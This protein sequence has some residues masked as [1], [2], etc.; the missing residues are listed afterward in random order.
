VS[1]K[2]RIWIKLKGRIRIRIRVKDRIRIRIK[3]KSRIRIRI[4]GMRIRNTGLK[5]ML[6]NVEVL[7]ILILAYGMLLLTKKGKSILPFRSNTWSQRL[8]GAV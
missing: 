2:I 6:L 7:Q 5:N 8:E 3:V 1:G 4:K